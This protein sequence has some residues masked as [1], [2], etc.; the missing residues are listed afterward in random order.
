MINGPDDPACD[1]RDLQYPTQPYLADDS[2]LHPDRP[3]QMI[4][5]SIDRG[6]AFQDRR[7]TF[8]DALASP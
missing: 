7:Q 8:L 4:P 6:R 5:G 2:V 1:I 3:L